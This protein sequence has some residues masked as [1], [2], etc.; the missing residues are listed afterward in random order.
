MECLLCARHCEKCFMTIVLFNCK[1]VTCRPIWPIDWTLFP[2]YKFE[3]VLKRVWALQFS[4]A[5]TISELF[6]P[7]PHWHYCQAPVGSCTCDSC[8]KTAQWNRPYLVAILLLR[9]R[10]NMQLDPC[11][12]VGKGSRIWTDSY[13]HRKALIQC[14]I[15]PCYHDKVSTWWYSVFV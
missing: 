7:L 15:F 12:T 10:K 4:T 9:Q 14:I 2:K 3:C 8:F 1:L 5:H 11:H 13:D 6:T